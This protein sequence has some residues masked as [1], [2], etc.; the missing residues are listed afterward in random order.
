MSRGLRRVALRGG[1]E[2][3]AAVVR[4]LASVL[5]TVQDDVPPVIAR[6]TPARLA[7][8]RDELDG[9]YRPI[10]GSGRRASVRA[11]IEWSDANRQVAAAFV[12]LREHK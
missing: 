5:G 4:Q 3:V 6:R 1:A 11:G 8:D 9:R 10:S 2:A 12:S 7:L